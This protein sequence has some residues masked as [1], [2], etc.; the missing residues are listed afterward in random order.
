[1]NN[2]SKTASVQCQIDAP[3]VQSFGSDPTFLRFSTVYDGKAKVEDLYFPD[4]RIMSNMSIL[5]TTIQVPIGGLA[6]YPHF[7]DPLLKY[8]GTV[9]PTREQHKKPE[10][11]IHNPDRNKF[12]LYFDERLTARQ[13]N[14]M[15]QYMQ[16]AGFVDEQTKQLTVEVV[17]FN[18]E[19]DLV[20]LLRVY[21][22]WENSGRIMWVVYLS[23]ACVS[24]QV[25]VHMCMSM[26]VIWVMYLLLA[27][28]CTHMHAYV[29]VVC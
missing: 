28:V 2:F 19:L 12:K 17:T 18:A 13:A 29:H 24:V 16:D 5:N 4:E 3:S 25:C 22:E 8:N 23:F 21:F 1:M 11:H 7:Y 26:E 10:R 27:S 20:A 6:F 9:P 14:N 15:V